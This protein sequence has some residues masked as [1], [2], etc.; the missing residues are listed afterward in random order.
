M[1][2]SRANM[3]LD[4]HVMAAVRCWDTGEIEETPQRAHRLANKPAFVRPQSS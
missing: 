1:K 4:L 2:F 3:D